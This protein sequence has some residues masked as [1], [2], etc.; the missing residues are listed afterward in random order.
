M[1]K[2]GYD[3]KRMAFY[4]AVAMLSSAGLLLLSLARGDKGLQSIFVSGSYYVMWLL[5]AL[6]MCSLVT[7]IQSRGFDFLTLW[8]IYRRGLGVALALTTMVFV[9]VP[10][11]MRILSDETNLLAV[12]RSMTYE[13]RVENLTEARQYYDMYWVTSRS[14]EKRNLLYPFSVHLLHVVSGYRVENAF[15]LNFMSLLGVLSLLCVL[16][17]PTFGFWGAVAVML[18]LVAQPIVCLMATSTSYEVFNLLF[19]L[20]SVVALRSFLSFPSKPAFSFLL[21]SLL[22]LA[23]VRYESLIIGVVVMLIVL[24]AGAARPGLWTNAINAWAPMCLVPYLWQR[25]VMRTVPDSNLPQ[26][27]WIK[28][29]GWEWFLPNLKVLGHDMFDWTGA[30]GYAGALNIVGIGALMWFLIWYGSTRQPVPR[31]DRLFSVIVGAALT[32]LLIIIIAYKIDVHP[33]NGRLYLPLLALLSVMVVDAGHRLV[34]GEIKFMGVV[35]LLLAI[36]FCFYHPVAMEDRLSHTL[37][38][39]REHKQLTQFL[40]KTKMQDVLVISPRPGQLVPYGYGSISFFTANR[41][42]NMLLEQWRNRLY[43]RILVFQSIS[44]QHKKPLAGQDLSEQFNLKTLQEFQNSPA[45][46]IRVSEVVNS[47]DNK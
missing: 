31:A 18:G 35:V 23:N 32:A 13:K 28:A 19:V 7:W 11:E 43:K 14:V 6:W 25:L 12:A 29:F 15:V 10:K 47:R 17:L 9:S 1:I 30:S 37:L 39:N 46:F 42:Q 26:G 24:G 34:R 33:M 44:Y 21:F 22:M 27:S 40:A 38:T 20:I 8:R 5:V 3:L 2:K 4:W 36:S 45:Y 16:T 41:E